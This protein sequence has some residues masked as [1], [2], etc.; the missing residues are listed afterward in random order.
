MQDVNLYLRTSYKGVKSSDGWWNSILEY[1]TD[2][3]PV[4][5]TLDGREHG[6][7]NRIA[8]I[9]LLKA[10]ERIRK[11]CALGIYAD[12]RHI[13]QGINQYLEQWKKVD[14][15]TVKGEPVKND[16]LWKQ[17]D[18]KIAPHLVKVEF[19]EHTEYSNWQAEEMMRKERIR[20]E[21]EQKKQGM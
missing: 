21:Q 2:K 9:G 13:E 6:T 20:N 11:P 17:I 8:L 3:G 5:L 10:L 1:Q 18:K 7:S 15:A 14:W 12:C 19:S 16:D 4:T